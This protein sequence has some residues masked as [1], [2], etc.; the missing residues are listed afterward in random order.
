[1]SYNTSKFGTIPSIINKVIG[2]KFLLYADGFLVT[3]HNK[4]YLEQ[5]V[6]KRC[7]H[8]MH[9]RTAVSSALPLFTGLSVSRL[10][11]RMKGVS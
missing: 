9:Q 7:D 1:M 6:Q 8:L 4:G 2:D 3:S 10:S 5:L 11:N